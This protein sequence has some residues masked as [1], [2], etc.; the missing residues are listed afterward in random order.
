MDRSK[1][2]NVVIGVKWLGFT[3][4][5]FVEC[6]NCNNGLLKKTVFLKI[7]ILQDNLFLIN[8]LDCLKKK[9]LLK[10]SQIVTSCIS[11]VKIFFMPLWVFIGARNSKLIFPPL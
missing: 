6:Y 11:L 10:R 3:L 2:W 8:S 1:K 9:V 7:E 5:F 4:L